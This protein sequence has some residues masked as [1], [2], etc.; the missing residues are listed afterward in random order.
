MIPC[1]YFVVVVVV[2]VVVEL[3]GRATVTKW[4]QGTYVHTTAL[5]ELAS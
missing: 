1:L 5:M 2:V 4:I 3:H